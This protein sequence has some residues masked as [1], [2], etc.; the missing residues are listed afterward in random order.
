MI[1]MNL[2]T[3]KN[4][5]IVTLHLDHEDC[6]SKRLSPYG[7]LHGDD[8]LGLHQ[9]APPPHAVKYQ[10]GHHELIVLPSKL[11]E[12][13]VRHQVDG[14]AAVDEHPGDWLPIDVTTNV[15]QLQVLA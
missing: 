1:D 8:T 14:S 2:I 5:T 13:R 10:V 15:Q 12:D 7:E 9:V 6:G 4:N 11:L 3:A